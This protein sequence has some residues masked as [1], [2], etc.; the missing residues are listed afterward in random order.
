MSTHPLSWLTRL[1]PLGW[2]MLATALHAGVGLTVWIYPH[3]ALARHPTPI[4]LVLSPVQPK[5]AAEVPPPIPDPAKPEAKPAPVPPKVAVPTRR[6]TNR[7][8]R[9][10]SPTPPAP[11][12]PARRVVGLSFG[13]TVQGGGSAFALGQT[14]E[15]ETARVAEP[16]TVAAPTPPPAQYNRRG[17]AAA[18]SEDAQSVLTRPKRKVR[19]KPKYPE[20]LRAAGVQADVV[21]QVRLSATGAVLEAKIIEAAAQDAFNKAALAAANIEQFEPARRDGRALEYTLSFTYHFV[22]ND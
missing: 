15:G 20:S 7:P 2:F 21:V 16:V 14:L 6:P 8:A 18:V 12:P 4:E 17:H 9:P 3:P 19:I 13:S 1:G 22:L 5:P 11:S 10:T